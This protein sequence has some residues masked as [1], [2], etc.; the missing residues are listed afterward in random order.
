MAALLE[1]AR[2]RWTPGGPNARINA[3]HPLAQGLVACILPG[4]TPRCY[5]TGAMPVSSADTSQVGTAWGPAR[6]IGSTAG[7]ISYGNH[8]GAPAANTD[9]TV[10]FLFANSGDAS[11]RRLGVYAVDNTSTDKPSFSLYLHNGNV[12]YSSVDGILAQTAISAGQNIVIA[13]R[14]G[15]N[16][17]LSVNGAAKV[18][19][20][21]RAPD[22]TTRAELRLGS[23]NNTYVNPLIDPIAAFMLWDHPLTDALA[24]RLYQ[25][26]F[27]MLDTRA[28]RHYTFFDGGAP[29]VTQGTWGISI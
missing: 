16:G 20:M 10:M 24:S 27:A 12:V 19:T 15:V 21:P 1:V 18:T 2:R 3:N 23:Y 17:Y 8:P 7:Y 5:V 22:T 14:S 11:L 28:P 26:P 13:T 6:Y 9:Q 4:V 29:A 25:D